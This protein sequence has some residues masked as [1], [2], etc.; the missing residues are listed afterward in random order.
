MKNMVITT[1]LGSGD[2]TRHVESHSKHAD[3]L[4]VNLTDVSFSDSAADTAGWSSAG[5]QDLQV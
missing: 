2:W 3:V 1:V 5:F 4:S